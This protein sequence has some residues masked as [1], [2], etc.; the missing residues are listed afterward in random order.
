LEPLHPRYL[1][2]MFLS[3]C[4]ESPASFETC[5]LKVSLYGTHTNTYRKGPYYYFHYSRKK[6]VVRHEPLNPS[7]AKCNFFG[8]RSYYKSGFNSKSKS[9]AR[10]AST[11]SVM[12][13]NPLHLALRAGAGQRAAG[14]GQGYLKGRG[15]LHF[16]ECGI[17]LLSVRLPHD[18]AAD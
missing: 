8:T 16:W 11:S 3:E 1:G 6:C 10:I 5:L 4:H 12:G 7:T 18:Q 17:E 15:D 9:C 14:S 13:C 2:W